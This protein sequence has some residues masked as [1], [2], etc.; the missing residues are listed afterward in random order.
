MNIGTFDKDALHETLVKTQSVKKQKFKEFKKNNRNKWIRFNLIMTFISVLFAV[1]TVF[2]I[3]GAKYDCLE[4]SLK[5]PLWFVFT[6]HATN[7]IA[8]FI[9]LIGADSRLC[10]GP[11]VFMY[12]IMEIAILVYMNVAY[13]ES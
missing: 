11:L 8:A 7:G 6:L 5:V 9:N 1:A 2:I 10:T 4:Q 12:G 3:H 13:F